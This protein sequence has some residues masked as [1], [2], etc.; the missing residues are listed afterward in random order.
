MDL[1]CLVDCAK[2]NLIA[3]N[4][5]YFFTKVFLFIEFKN[6]NLFQRPNSFFVYSKH[7]KLIVSYLIY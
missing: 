1:S 6:H 2:F 5:M 4:S 3:P 7:A